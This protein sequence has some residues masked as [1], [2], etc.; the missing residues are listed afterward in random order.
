M[1]TAEL[2]TIDLKRWA[3]PGKP[4]AK[5]VPGVTSSDLRLVVEFTLTPVFGGTPTGIAITGRKR[6]LVNDALSLAPAHASAVIEI[7]GMKAL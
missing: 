1:P 7:V 2:S 6:R 3:Y 4:S 5:L